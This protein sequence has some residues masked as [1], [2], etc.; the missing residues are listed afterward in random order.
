M[1]SIHYNA[2]SPAVHPCHCLH[3]QSF[4][5]AEQFSTAPDGQPVADDVPTPST[6]S[7]PETTIV[8]D[9]HY[10]RKLQEIEDK[11]MQLKEKLNLTQEK[12]AKDLASEKNRTQKEIKKAAKKHSKERK[13]TQK[14]I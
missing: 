10:G 12:Q 9:S 2:Q 13:K 14:Q 6:I 4:A 3:N 8:D 5:S 7:Q 11:K 1:H